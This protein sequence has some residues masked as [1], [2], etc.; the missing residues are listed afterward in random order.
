[1]PG[2]SF[3]ARVALVTA[4]LGCAAGS[5]RAQGKLDEVLTPYLSRYELPALA[6]A[7]VQDG[8]IVAA[9]AVGTRRAGAD[10]PVTVNDRFHLG[11]DTKAMTAL[12]AGMLVEA[13]KLRWE[14]TIAD[15][16]PDLA[17]KMDAGLK[18]VTVEQLLSHTSGIPADND[19]FDK[20]VDKA[21]TQDGNLDEQRRWLVQQWA[22]QPLESKPGTKFAYSNMNY[23]IVGVMLEC[24]TGKTW[25]EL[26][27]ER[28]FTPLE[29][30]SAGLG[31][32]MTLGKIDAPLGHVI[33]KG[34]QKAYL[35]GPNGDNQLLLGPAGTAHMSV[36]DF[37][38]WAGWNAG[39][40][41][42]EPKL[43]KPETFKK[44]HTMVFTMPEKKDAPPGT[45]SRGKYG[46]G[47]GEVEI[48]WA[49]EPLMYH[50]GSNG[51]NLAHIWVEPKRDFAMVIVTNIS[52]AKANKALLALAPE[53]YKKFGAGGDGKKDP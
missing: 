39:Q 20:L 4:I 10:V 15:I 51:K 42:R 5:A 32:Q 40:G 11:S 16:L 9:G 48:E 19:T 50:G 26:I 27:T 29:L 23:V 6:A 28:V 21:Q 2:R 35:A 34:K 31:P 36:L 33:E 1:M 44:L 22:T 45:P 18:R 24:L 46:L 13:G 49:P 17:E 52:D 41:K 14:A 43:V 25:E 38:R 53:L 3:A 8:K 37:G 7:V 30:R 47:W 12:L